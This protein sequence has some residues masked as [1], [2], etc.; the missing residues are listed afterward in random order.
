MPIPTMRDRPGGSEIVKLLSIRLGAAVAAAIVFNAAAV[1]HAEWSPLTSASDGT[2]YSIDPDRVRTVGGRRQVWLKG[3]HSQ[4]RTERARS[5][6]TLLSI[7][8]SASTIRTLVENKYDS[9]GKTISSRSNTDYGVGYNPITPE[10]IGED[11][12]RSVCPAE[13]SL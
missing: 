2:V 12:A 3:D 8:C 1:T 10:T 11:V 7:D 6:M 5:S 4:D 9:Y 13:A